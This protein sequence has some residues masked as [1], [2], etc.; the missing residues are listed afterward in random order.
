MVMP[1]HHYASNGGKY[2]PQCE[3]DNLT[4]TRSGGGR[5]PYNDK[6]CDDCGGTWREI[7]SVSGY[8]NFEAGSEED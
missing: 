6:R 3:S 2:C 1:S 8:E 5:D 7:L 4:V